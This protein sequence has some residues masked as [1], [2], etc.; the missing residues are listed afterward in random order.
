M[1]LNKAAMTFQEMVEEARKSVREMHARDIEANMPDALYADVREIEE[2]DEGH[3]PGAIH[4]PL[5]R[6]DSLA[7]PNSSHA[8]AEIT[9]HRDAPIVVYCELGKRSL[10]AGKALQELGYCN[11]VSLKGGYHAWKM[12]R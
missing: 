4:V 8:A 6:L 1:L 10:L 5:S 2:W 7:D 12:H 3:I 9:R 11:V